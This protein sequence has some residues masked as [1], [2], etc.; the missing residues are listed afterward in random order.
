MSRGEGYQVTS[1]DELVIFDELLAPKWVEM[2][3]EIRLSQVLSPSLER[4]SPRGLL[5]LAGP[6]P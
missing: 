4:R 3:A 1:I 6:E 2:G 5:C